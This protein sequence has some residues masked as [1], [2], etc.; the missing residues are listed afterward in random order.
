MLEFLKIMMD[1]IRITTFQAA[2]IET[3]RNPELGSERARP[4][5][6]RRTTRARR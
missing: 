2:G 5:D 3:R 6:C 4:D 1:V